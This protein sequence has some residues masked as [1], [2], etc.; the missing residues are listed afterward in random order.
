[1][2]VS[3]YELVD[4]RRV[5]V[6]RNGG[7]M[8]ARLLATGSTSEAEVYQAAVLDTTVSYFG[9]L[10][11]SAIRVSPRGGGPYWDVEIDYSPIPPGEAI[12]NPGLDGGDGPAQPLAP[13]PSTPIGPGFAFSTGGGTT[14]IYQA[15]ETRSITRS[16]PAIA[17]GRQLKDHHGAVNVTDDGAEGVDIVSRQG[18]WSLDVRRNN[19]TLF[20]FSQLFYATG[21]VNDAP[22]YGF[23]AGEVLYLGAEGRF[24]V[25][26]LWQI[27][28]KFSVTPNEVNKVIARDENGAAQ[29]TVPV[30]KGWDYVWV[31]YFDSFVGGVKRLLPE[32]AYVQQVYP[33]VSFASLE[34][35][36]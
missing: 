5:T 26:D 20:Y 6:D 4:S 2:A 11:R 31:Q 19:V 30:K 18:E 28:H 22:F 35:G 16:L 32:A 34:I 1:M 10:F 13:D 24:T 21:C 27:T 29:I 25:N 17:A 8:T 23:A 7:G 33:T 15:I 3:L 12:Q 36:A 9:T 14:K